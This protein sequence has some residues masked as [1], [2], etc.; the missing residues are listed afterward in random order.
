M[1]TSVVRLEIK[2]IV[3]AS[4][5]IVIAGATV[6]TRGEAIEEETA[7]TQEEKTTLTGNFQ[8]NAA[9]MTFRWIRQKVNLFGSV[10]EEESIEHKM[11]PQNDDSQ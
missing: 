2:E 8:T 3:E 6:V 5:G 9:E 1:Q 11:I 7:W 10:G 4:I